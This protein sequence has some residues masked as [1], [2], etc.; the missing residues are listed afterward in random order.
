MGPIATAPTL[1]GVELE[2]PGAEPSG[3]CCT[4]QSRA[5]RHIR[6][7]QGHRDTKR[8]DSGGL[9]LVCTATCLLRAPRCSNASV[10]ALLGALGARVVRSGSG[11]HRP[12]LA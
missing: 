6:E 12:W 7:P 10:Q 9:P 3:S 11:V 1:Q 5:V 8:L 2:T 4:A